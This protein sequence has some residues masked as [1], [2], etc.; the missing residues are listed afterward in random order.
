MCTFSFAI[1]LAR[2]TRC[3]FWFHPVMLRS[4]VLKPEKHNFRQWTWTQSITS[5]NTRDNVQ[6]T[7]HLQPKANLTFSMCTRFDMYKKYAEFRLFLHTHKCL[8]LLTYFFLSVLLPCGSATV[9]CVRIW[10]ECKNIQNILNRF[11]LFFFFEIVES[12]GPHLK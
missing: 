11:V 5:L 12:P 9:K 6:R 3:L 10:N 1:S 8:I 4:V 2:A 7:T